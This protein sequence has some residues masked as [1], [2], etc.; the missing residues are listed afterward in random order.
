MKFI[1]TRNT[2]IVKTLSEAIQSGLAEDGGLFVPDHIPKIDIDVFISELSYIEF[3]HKLLQHYFTGDILEQSL[4]SMC[5]NAFNFPVP[6]KKLDETTFLLELFHGPTSSFKD[7]GARFLAECLN[8]ISSHDKTTVLVATSGDTG[9]A[10]ASA[11]Y[12][13]S[14]I[15]VIILYPKDKISERQKHQITCWDNNVIA[16]A[17]NG[18][19]DDCQRLVKQAFQDPW[20]R[21]KLHLSSAN[22]I[23]IGR[24]LPQIVYYAYASMQFYREYRSTIGFIVPTGNLGNATAGYLVKMMGFP[25][26]EIVVATNA[27]K[28]I[29]DYLQTGVFKPRPGIPTLANAMDV[30]DP[31][32]MERLQHLFKDYDALKKNVTALSVSDN[33]IKKT[34]LEVY[35]KYHTIICPHTATGFFVRQQLSDKPWIIA[36]TADPSKFENVIEPI[37]HTQIPIAPALK[38]LL[39][40][41]THEIEVEANLESCKL[42]LGLYP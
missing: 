33:D 27:N 23:N 42:A 6:L 10:V 37:I 41:P 32:N 14:H 7:F 38:E 22:S 5:K 24:L 9:S 35:K 12:L 29:P 8:N 28:T 2:N 11:F 3:S 21:Q 30:G 4:E 34:I 26:R 36:A 17:V 1:S 39:N 18:T 15:N 40:R 20:W 13:K 19:F 25:I 16:L 31:S